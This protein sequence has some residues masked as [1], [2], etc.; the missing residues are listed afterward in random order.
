MKQLETITEKLIQDPL[1]A[2]TVEIPN[3][4]YEGAGTVI[5]RNATG[6]HLA[7]KYGSV[8]AFWESLYA[9]GITALDIHPRRQNG[10][11]GGGRQVNYKPAGPCIKVSLRPKAGGTE[12]QALGFEPDPSAFRTRPDHAWNPMGP[13]MNAPMPGMNAMQMNYQ[14]MDY[15]RLS[16]EYEKLLDKYERLDE[17]H[18]TLEKEHFMA[19]QSK[20]S[21]AD[22]FKTIKDVA[23]NLPAILGAMQGGK[24]AAAAQPG[25]AGPDLDDNVQELVEICSSDPS[26]P[27]MLLAIANGIQTNEQFGGRL[28][29]LLRE[30]NFLPKLETA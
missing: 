30:F 23:P 7:T 26:F 16:R 3:P 12:P 6:A 14:A 29:D 21:R 18:K 5:E 28:I 11:K 8:A 9:K 22:L 20:S 2:V 17:R 10:T 13:G 25:L 19:V 4:Q 15:H 1:F 27:R 24:F